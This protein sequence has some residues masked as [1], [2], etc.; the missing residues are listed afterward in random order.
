MK[1]NLVVFKKN[2]PKVLAALKRGDIDYVANS[3]WSFADEFFSFLLSVG[4]FDFVESIYP[5]PG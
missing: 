2:K 4:F 1:N 3:R 5:H